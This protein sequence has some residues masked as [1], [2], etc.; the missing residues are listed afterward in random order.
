MSCCHSWRSP[1]LSPETTHIT[2]E[3]FRDYKK[4]F[5]HILL[6]GKYLAIGDMEDDLKEIEDDI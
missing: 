2:L 4:K 5:N 1:A 3:R 6:A